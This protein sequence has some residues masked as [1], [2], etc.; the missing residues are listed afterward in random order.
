MNGLLILFIFQYHNYFLE[1]V[2]SLVY[3]LIYFIYLFICLK[4]FLTCINL[5]CKRLLK[6]PLIK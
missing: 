6:P 4:K 1:F 5:S 3:L 2:F